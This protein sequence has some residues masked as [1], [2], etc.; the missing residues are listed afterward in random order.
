MKKK[1]LSKLRFRKE[2]PSSRITSDTIAEHRQRILAGGRRFKYPVQYARH[3][4]VINA[5][6]LSVVAIVI[7]GIVGWQQLYV[8]QNSSTFMYR[9]TKVLPLPIASVDG[10]QVPYSDYLLKY[11][12]AVHYLQEKEQVDLTTTDGKRQV[13]Y[14]KQQAMQDSIA[15]AYAV[16]LASSLH[17]SISDD[18]LQTFLAEQRQS[19]DGVVSEQTYDAVILDYY[20]WTPTEYQYATKEKLL[21]QKV[22]Y[23]ID[24]TASSLVTSIGAQVAAP[25]SNFQS[26]VSG[27]G[28]NPTKVSYGTSGLVPKTNEDGGLAAAASNLTKGEVSSVIKSTTGDGYYFIRLLDSNSTQVNYEFIQI[29]LTVFNAELKQLTDQGKVKEYITISKTTK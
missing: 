12:S 16:K 14:V 11:L 29:P 13:T 25:N 17:I 28:A 2:E 3:R 26:I 15:D 27:V 7:V 8:A 22:S 18:E 4:L 23:A 1:L 21:L 20:G 5:I 10:Q 24:T 6:I 19:S 9:V